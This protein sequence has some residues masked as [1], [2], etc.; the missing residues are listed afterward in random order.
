MGYYTDINFKTKK[1][2]KEALQDGK[3]ITVY[4]PGGMFESNMV[5]RDGTV[6]LEGPHYPEPHKWYAQGVMKDGLLISIK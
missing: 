5:P 4:Q 6:Y 2:L 1:A 3:E